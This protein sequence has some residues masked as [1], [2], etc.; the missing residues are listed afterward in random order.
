MSNGAVFTDIAERY[1]RL[2]RILSLGRDQAW[3]L[4]A[5]RHLPEGRLLDLGA[6]TGAANDVFGDRA[7]VALDPSPEMLSLN[8]VGHRVVGVGEQLP[9]CSGAFDAV[10]SAYVFRNLDSVPGTMG[11]IRRV[12]RPGGKVGIVDLGRPEQ[13]WKA[14][15]HRA[16]TSVVLPAAGMTIGA[17]EEYTYLHRTL[18][19]H[20]PPDVLLSGHGMVVERIWRMGP[21]G[22]VWGAILVKP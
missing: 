18:D 1:D 4:S 15:L 5:I 22:F 20:P 11:E 8:Q 9:F 16:G 6:G 12:L 2:N 10:F 14:K 13:P 3:R 7:V 21:L 17:R 19:K